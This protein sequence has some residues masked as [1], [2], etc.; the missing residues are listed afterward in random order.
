MPYGDVGEEKKSEKI[1]NPFS[2]PACEC[3]FGSVFLTN[4]L[5]K[6]NTQYTSEFLEFSRVFS[7]TTVNDYVVSIGIYDEVTIFM[8]IS[9]YT[10][11]IFYIIFIFFN[12]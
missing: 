9:T 7:Y 10:I 3:S 8:D 4:L 11:I 2:A 1:Y 5:L 12:F 6:I